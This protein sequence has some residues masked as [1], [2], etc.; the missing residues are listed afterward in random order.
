[1]NTENGTLNLPELAAYV[2]SRYDIVPDALKL[3]QNKGLKTLWKVTHRN[4]HRCLK[5]LKHIKE[6]AVFTVNAQRYIASCGGCVPKIYLNKDNEPITEYMGQLF[7]LY[8]WID[9]KDFNFKKPADL[10]LALKGLG[11]FHVKSKGYYPPECAKI[12]S[13]LGRWPHQYES[14]L[15]R[16]LKW[17]KEAS[18]HQNIPVYKAYLKWIDKIID[19]GNT[20]IEALNHSA[21]PEMTSIQLEQAALCH[22]DYGEGNALY[23]GETV[24]VI[25]LDGVTYDLEM[26]DLRKIIGKRME[27]RGVWDKMKIKEIVDWYGRSNP[28]S[29][30][31]KRVLAIDLLFPHWFFATVKNLFKKNKSLS[32]SEIIRIA[33]I[34]HSK[35]N[36]LKDLY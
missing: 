31:Q 18:N 27:K 21:Y 26:R 19:M 11:H 2:L 29:I 1:M 34:E 25:D 7:V 22:Q 3:I 6:K 14:M 9:G 32:S 33:E 28:L 20:A 5:R 8:E 4:E 24:Y 16:M 35:V 15:N 30:E 12:S 10:R 17:K 36:I 23:I 13:K